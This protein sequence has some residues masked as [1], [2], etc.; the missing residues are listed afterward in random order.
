M[1]SNSSD[2]YSPMSPI[3]QKKSPERITLG[4]IFD[5]ILKFCRYFGFFRTTR[6]RVRKR[7]I[8]IS[9]FFW[10]TRVLQIGLYIKHNMFYPTM[11]KEFSSDRDVI[12]RHI[13]NP[14]WPPIYGLNRS[15]AAARSRVQTALV[16]MDIHEY[17]KVT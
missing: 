7:K 3:P 1:L 14:R 17:N 2:F 4:K 8:P 12:R 15:S 10:D 13:K 11:T 5:G 16:K 9:F 6:I